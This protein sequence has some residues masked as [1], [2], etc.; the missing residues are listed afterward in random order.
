MSGDSAA[1]LAFGC[2]FVL[3]LLYALRIALTKGASEPDRS[4]DEEP[5][6]AEPPPPSVVTEV[7]PVLREQ[8]TVS[9]EERSR[10]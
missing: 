8:P 10:Q 4:L 3:L 1:L 7:K 2:S 6:R 5:R 9:G